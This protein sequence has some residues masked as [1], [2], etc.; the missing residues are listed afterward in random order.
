M[1]TVRFVYFN[2]L[3][4]SS[5]VMFPGKP[6]QSEAIYAGA[7]GEAGLRPIEVG[8]RVQGFPCQH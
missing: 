2:S 5:L 7:Y 3:Y 4:C 6:C 1:A 8:T